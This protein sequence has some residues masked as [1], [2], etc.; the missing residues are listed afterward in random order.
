MSGDDKYCAEKVAEK[1]TEG[2]PWLRWVLV[3]DGARIG[4][5]VR[6]PL[7]LIFPTGAMLLLS[8]LVVVSSI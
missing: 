6:L 8:S 3:R 5:Q 2:T 1:G 4:G 7:A